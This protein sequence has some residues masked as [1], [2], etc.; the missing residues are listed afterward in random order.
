VLK[1]SAQKHK[2]RQWGTPSFVRA[3]LTNGGHDR[4]RVGR[5]VVAEALSGQQSVRV[6]ERLLID[7]NALELLTTLG[8][9]HVPVV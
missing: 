7:I 1:A 9:A 4:F 3:D 5:K 6:S 8:V 2:P